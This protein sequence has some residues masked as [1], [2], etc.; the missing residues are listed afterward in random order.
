MGTSRG[1][2][3]KFRNYQP[4]TDDLK[5]NRLKAKDAPSIVIGNELE[6]KLKDEI[7]SKPTLLNIAPQKPNAD[8]KRDVEKKLRRLARRT[9]KAIRELIQEKLAAEDVD[10]YDDAPDANDVK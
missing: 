5:A 6:K 9:Q 7:Q 2:V 10:A 8:L 3:L 1:K 4:R